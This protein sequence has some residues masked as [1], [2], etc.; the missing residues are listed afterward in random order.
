MADDI[1]LYL[2]ECG[3]IRIPRYVVNAG[4]ALNDGRVDNPTPWYLLTHPRGNVVIDGGNAPQVAED[5]IK[6]WGY[7]AERSPVLMRPDQAMLPLAGG[8]VT[9]LHS[10]HSASTPSANAA[11]KSAPPTGRRSARARMAV[12]TGPDG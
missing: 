6:H 1:R 10:R 9:A 4:D 12:A 8:T 3:I 5:P 11:R 7:L 2:F